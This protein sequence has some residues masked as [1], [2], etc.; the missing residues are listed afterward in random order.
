MVAD[1]HF[2]NCH[3]HWPPADFIGRSTPSAP[4]TPMHGP[5]WR[6]SHCPRSPDRRTA[7]NR[8]RHFTDQTDQTDQTDHKKPDPV[9]I[10]KPCRRPGGPRGLRWLSVRIRLFFWRGRL[11]CPL[12]PLGRPGPLYLK[13]PPFL[14][15]VIWSYLTLASFAPLA[16]F[17]FTSLH[18]PVAPRERQS[19]LPHRDSTG[20]SVFI[21]C[22]CL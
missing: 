8:V 9:L 5:R 20:R 2:R 14:A 21:I 11:L 6:P 1:V 15:D 18:S 19:S 17:A 22:Q 12:C 7:K 16:S 3:F 13:P 10:G 4:S